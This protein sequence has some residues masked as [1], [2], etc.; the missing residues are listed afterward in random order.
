MGASIW[1]QRLIR[2]GFKLLWK[3]KKPALVREPVHF[4]PPA[5]QER[6]TVLDQQVEEMLSKDAIEEVSNVSSPGF[7]SRL[8]AIP[9]ALGGFRPILD[10]SPLNAFLRKI[11]FQMESPAIIR[12]QIR[13]GD[14]ASSLDLKDAYFHVKVR[15]AD[16]KWL[17][18]TWTGRTYQY[19]VLPF[20]LSLSPWAFTKLVRDLVTHCRDRSIRLHSYL[21]DWLVLASRQQSCHSHMTRLRALTS[22]L[23]FVIQEEKSEFIP[24][25][26]FTF[27]GILFKTR[28]MTVQPSQKRL[29]ALRDLLTQLGSLDYSTARKLAAVLGKM[30]SLAPLLPLGRLHKRP[31]QREFHKRFNQAKEKWSKVI[32]IHPWFNQVTD[33]WRDEFWLNSVVPIVPPDPKA[34]VFTDASEVG[35]GAHM[36]NLTASGNWPLTSPQP[37]I[38][39]LELEAVQN[40]LAEFKDDIPQGQVLIRSDNQTVVALL[41]HQ[42]GTHAPALSMRAEE[43]ILWA[44]SQGWNLLAKHIA[45]SA[46]IMADLLSR[47]DKIIQTEWTLKHEALEQVWSQED[48]PMLDLFAT[49]FSTRLPVYVSPVPDPQA[50]QIDAMEM[51][52]VGI[53]AYAFPPWSLLQQVVTKIRKDQPRLILIAPF[54]PS[55]AWFPDLL[56]LCHSRPLPLRLKFGDLCQPRS[57]IPHGNL[58]TLNLH[59]WRLCGNTCAA[60]DCLKAL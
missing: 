22:R 46:N 31:L 4:P 2:R 42:G 32:L 37:H 15:K 20:G 59:V 13:Q 10:L 41:N 3:D 50:L 29:Q 27:L 47:P 34:T 56:S 23:G 26:E 58:A 48:K 28:P 7:Y 24:S 19:K 12:N 6:C 8:F 60:G 38:N 14:W 40:A 54:W 44:H 35:W 33:R 36:G 39:W 21:D 18:F 25:Q 1:T 53:Q 45:G 17:R 43:I 52:W 55:K 16:R 57:G 30:E 5:A 11:K 51:S 49:K 9:K